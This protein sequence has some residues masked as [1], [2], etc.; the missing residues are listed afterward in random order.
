M[1]LRKE[2]SSGSFCLTLPEHLSTRCREGKGTS[3]E[4]KDRGCWGGKRWRQAGA[5][6]HGGASQRRPSFERAW[7]GPSTDLGA[8]ELCAE[9][10]REGQKQKRTVRGQ[11]CQEVLLRL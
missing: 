5:G 1:P 10:G 9:G 4:R 2:T 3:Q 8:A 11:G 7:E 6:G